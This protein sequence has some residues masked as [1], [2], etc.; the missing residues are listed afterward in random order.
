MNKAA[1]AKRDFGDV[2]SRLKTI[3]QKY[4]RGSLKG[5]VY[6]DRPNSYCLTGPPSEFTRG[7]PAWFGA[8]VMGKAYVSYHLIGVYVSP[9]LL[10]DISP[11]LRKRMQG[12]SCFNFKEVDDRLFK[13]LAALTEKSYKNLRELQFFG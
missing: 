11:E 9:D 2:Y 10:K 5:G 7:K 3:M 12:K 8:V 6:G 4:E 13:E 1:K